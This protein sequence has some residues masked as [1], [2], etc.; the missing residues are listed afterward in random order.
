MLIKL[1]GAASGYALAWLVTQREDAAAY[2]RFELGLTVLAIG[3]LAARLG[4]D[5]VMVKWLAS[6]QARELR[7]IQLKLVGRAMLVTGVAGLGLAWLT[8]SGRHLLTSWSGDP[9]TLDMWPWVA[10]GIPVLAVW[11]LS[12]EMLRGLSRMKQYAL[13]QQGLLTALAV[14]VMWF[15]SFDVVQAYAWAVGMV[16]ILAVAMVLTSLSWQKG[17]SEELALPEWSWKAMFSTGWPMLM[18]SAMYLV[19][20]WSDTLLVAYHLEEDQVGIYRLT[21]KLA[22]VVTLVQAAVNSYA[23][24]L[25]AER[26]AVGDHQGVRDTLR[27]ATLL[28]VAFSIPAFLAIVV[29]GPSVLGWFGSE[30]VLGTSC[31]MWLA[32]GQLSMTLCG[33][34]M[35]VLNMTGHERISNRILWTTALVNVGLNLLA[36]PRW[37]IVGAAM[38]TAVS[39]A[40]WNVG[41]AWAV[42]SKLGFAVWLDLWKARRR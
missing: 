15:S 37:G 23:A 38:A 2:G 27:H 39:L 21:F 14:A 35:Y 6:S 31:L 33:P 30:F 12:A 10:L 36:I 5:G 41:A 28:N 20:S 40:I 1:L 9:M 17:G 22:A 8:Y 7:T 32:V 19:M 16:A 34:V 3:A 25:F 13:S 24:P 11:A 29:F 18:G 4:L 42:H 26:H